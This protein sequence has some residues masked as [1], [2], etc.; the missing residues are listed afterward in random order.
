MKC[1]T[2]SGEYNR[3]CSYNNSSF[4]INFY[5]KRHAPPPPLQYSLIKYNSH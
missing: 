4:L 1:L 5:N 2:T 3:D